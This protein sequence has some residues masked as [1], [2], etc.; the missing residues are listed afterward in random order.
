MELGGQF[1]IVSGLILMQKWLV[2]QY[3]VVLIEMLVNS[4]I[5]YTMQDDRI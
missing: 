3:D 4:T 1:V 5:F 2:G